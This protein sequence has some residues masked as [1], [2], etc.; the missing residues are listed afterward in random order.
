MSMV[1]SKY[2]TCEQCGEYCIRLMFAPWLG[3]TQEIISFADRNKDKYESEDCEV[4][5]IGQPS[6]PDDKDG[7]LLTA[8]IW[9]TLERAENIRPSDFRK[10]IVHM[11]ESHCDLDGDCKSPYGIDD[12]RTLRKNY[13]F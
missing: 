12:L 13:G 7:P 9:P 3:D 8:K 2:W 6:D 5:I 1:E 11:E 10:H 4:W